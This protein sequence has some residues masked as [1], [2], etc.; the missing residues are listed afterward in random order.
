MF[1]IMINNS[2]NK[3]Y[4]VNTTCNNCFRSKYNNS[5]T[6]GGG[7]VGIKAGCLT[8]DLGLPHPFTGFFLNDPS[9]YLRE[10]WRKPWKT[11]N[12]LVDK[13]NR[14]LNLA[15]PVFQFWALPL[16][17]WWGLF[18][19]QK[20]VSMSIAKLQHLHFFNPKQLLQALFI[21][22]CLLTNFL[23]F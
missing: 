1:W 8:K 5:S 17:H 4:Q 2:I 7:G 23:F 13:H 3:Y 12:S 22:W 16:R 9:P 14:G 6:G 19:R 18:I 11:P 21:W 20:Q 10:F 15:P